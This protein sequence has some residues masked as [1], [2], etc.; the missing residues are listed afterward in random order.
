VAT[1]RY[2]QASA[3]SDPTWRAWGR[4]SGSRRPPAGTGGVSE[5]DRLD[6]PPGESLSSSDENA[7]RSIDN[8]QVDPRFANRDSFDFHLEPG[9]PA[10]DA[11]LA[12]R[13]K[14]ISRGSPRPQAGGVGIGVYEFTPTEHSRYG[15]VV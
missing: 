6:L 12:D 13:A 10:S 5:T 8:S 3:A 15:V 2:G 11:G 14:R 9:S 1:F 4:N 7:Y